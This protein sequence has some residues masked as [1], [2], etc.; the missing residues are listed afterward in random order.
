MLVADAFLG[1]VDDSDVATRVEGADEL[2]VT[3]DG[4]ERRRSRVRTTTE[5]GT[6]LGIVIARDLRDGDVLTADGR[7]VVVSLEPVPALTVDFGAVESDPT[8][9]AMDVL[10]LGHALGNRHRQI[11]IEGSHAY[12]PLSGD[13]DRLLERIEPHLPAGAV[14]DDGRV[15]P[16]LFDDEA[17]THPRGD[18]A[19]GEHGHRNTGDVHNHAVHP[20]DHNEGDTE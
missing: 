13:R 6:D 10:A 3:L 20:G 7:P 4:T 11:A 1:T 5:D 18:H 16:A 15:S 9:T 12:L 17:T 8:A 2:R 14:L 19:A